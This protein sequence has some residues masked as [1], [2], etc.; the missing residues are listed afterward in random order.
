MTCQTR[1][2]HLVADGGNSA[3]TRYAISA[4][5]TP[6]RSFDPVGRRRRTVFSVALVIFWR[7]CGEV[8]QSGSVVPG[9]ERYESG[10]RDRPALSGS[11]TLASL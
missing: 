8:Q 9:R 5:S 3:V 4:Q 11:R 7:M 2:R 1:H 6:E 10:L